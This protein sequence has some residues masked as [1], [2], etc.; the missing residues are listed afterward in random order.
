MPAAKNSQHVLQHQIIGT[1]KSLKLKLVVIHRLFLP[2]HAD[3][4]SRTVYSPCT[5]YLLLEHLT[6][7]V[8]HGLSNDNVPF[9]ITPGITG[10]N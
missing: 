10:K 8:A 7:Q 4:G 5:V 3:V 6:Q 2:Q 9:T 1:N